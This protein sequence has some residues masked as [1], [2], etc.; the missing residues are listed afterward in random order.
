MDEH[1][2]P[3]RDEQIARKAI[4]KALDGI[5]DETRKRVL[6]RL[7]DKYGTNEARHAFDAEIAQVTAE[8]KATVAPKQDQIAALEAA[9]KWDELPEYRLE[10][11]DCSRI[12]KLVEAHRAGMVMGEKGALLPAEHAP[13]FDGVQPFVVEHDWASAFKSAADFKPDGDFS[14]DFNL[15]YQ[16]CAFE[17]RI[18]G[19]TVIVV[20]F[21]PDPAVAAASPDL[22]AGIRVPSLPYIDCGRGYW[23]CGGQGARTTRSMVF[24][25]EQIRAIC[26][27]LDAE[28]A[29][30]EVVRAPAALNEKR[31]KRGDLPLYDYH[32]IK[33]HGRVTRQQMPGQH[34]THRSPR[35]HFRRGHWRHYDTHKTWIRWTLVGDPALGFIDKSY[36]L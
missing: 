34:G 25:W 11:N 13:W 9:L 33:L 12:H 1:Y 14:D 35:L 30:R 28:V 10:R 7:G 23:F 21:Q 15:P 16:H 5:D 6:G 27:A 3:T 4:A 19:R 18:S 22:P 17:F 8:M 2:A 32:V 36:R 29:T 31:N 20:S 24:A 26:I